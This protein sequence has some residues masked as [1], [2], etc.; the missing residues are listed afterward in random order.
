MEKINTG[1][2]EVRRASHVRWLVTLALNGAHISGVRPLP[3]RTNCRPTPC[4]RL[5]QFVFFV[6]DFAARLAWQLSRGLTEFGDLLLLVLRLLFVMDAWKALV[7]NKRQSSSDR[8]SP[9][10]PR[11]VHKFT[12]HS[13]SLSTIVRGLM[14]C[15]SSLT[16]SLLYEWDKIVESSSFLSTSWVDQ[17]LLTFKCHAV[18]CR[19]YI[20]SWH[21]QNEADHRHS[22]TT[23]LS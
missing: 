10:R 4:R 2:T 21:E 11:L 23:R 16:T 14:S 18:D 5:L 6:N 3:R 17:M 13:L 19:R 22:P 1:N 12:M 9:V 20:D 8:R 7:I 15:T